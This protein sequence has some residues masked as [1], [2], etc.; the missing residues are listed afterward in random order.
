[1]ELDKTM[2]I[3]FFN[4]LLQYFQNISILWK[5]SDFFSERSEGRVVLFVTSEVRSCLW[6][7]CTTLN[8]SGVRRAQ[9]KVSCLS[10]RR[11]TGL[12]RVR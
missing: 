7:H 9:Q 2:E 1:M 4:L 6:C 10:R 3:G 11:K 5:R 8:P 12:V